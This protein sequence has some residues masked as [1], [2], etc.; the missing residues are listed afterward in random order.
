MSVVRDYDVRD[1][2]A[3]HINHEYCDPVAMTAGCFAVKW[4]LLSVIRCCQRGMSGTVS[5]VCVRGLQWLSARYTELTEK[6][7]TGFETKGNTT[8]LKR[9]I[10]TVVSVDCNAPTGGCKEVSQSWTPA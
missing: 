3:A 9:Y 2:F 4:V 5:P 1:S 7:P 8:V 10:G 6:Q